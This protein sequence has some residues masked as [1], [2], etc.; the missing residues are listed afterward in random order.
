MTIEV[1]FYQPFLSI[2]DAPFPNDTRVGIG[3]YGAVYIPARLLH[4]S[5]SDVFK[6]GIDTDTGVLVLKDTVFVELNDAISIVRDPVAKELLR[7][8]KLGILRRLQR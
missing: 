3:K 6:R 2:D 8:L 5:E 4:I 1:D 7:A